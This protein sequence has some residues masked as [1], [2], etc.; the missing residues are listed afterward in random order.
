MRTDIPQDAPTD[1]YYV[2]ETTGTILGERRHR[3]ASSLYETRKQAEAE[4]TRL[5]AMNEGKAYSVWKASTY[6]E[7]A[8]WAHDL[9]LED[10]SMLR[11][12]LRTA[13]K[14]ES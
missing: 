8:R 3:A 13:V 10:G 5:A 7:P 14:G 9:V 1:V 4:F 11:A 6:I 12:D 2:V